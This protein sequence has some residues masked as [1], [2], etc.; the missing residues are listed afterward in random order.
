MAEILACH[1][2]ILRS[3]WNFPAFFGITQQTMQKCRG[4]KKNVRNKSLVS[5]DGIGRAALWARSTMRNASGSCGFNHRRN[6]KP[7]KTTRL[8]LWKTKIDL[9][10]Q[11]K[12][13]TSVHK[14]F[15]STPK[16]QNSCCTKKL[17]HLTTKDKRHHSDSKH[18]NCST[19]NVQIQ[20][21]SLKNEKHPCKSYNRFVWR[22]N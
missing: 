20:S 22:T 8:Y 16:S 11:Q 15:K 14:I 5:R 10:K 3:S 9:F 19:Q 18:S 6:V 2:L 4:L 7:D 12:L 13:L 17:Q 21:T 1:F